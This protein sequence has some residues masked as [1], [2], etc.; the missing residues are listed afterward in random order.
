VLGHA[1]KRGIFL[2]L[3]FLIMIYLFTRSFYSPFFILLIVL[4]LLIAF[5]SEDYRLF[6]WITITFF[7]SHLL[8]GYLDNFIGSFQLPQFA[9]VLLSQLLIL[10]PIL[11]M[12]MV[13]NKFNKST[14]PYFRKP[15]M[16]KD[17]QLF[18]CISWKL[19][20]IIISI[21]FILFLIGTLIIKRDELT[22]LHLLFS[23][24]FSI[25]HTGLGEVLWRGILLPHFIA[26]TNKWLGI[27]VTSSAFGL[28]MTI[29]GFSSLTTFSYIIL[30]LLFGYLT[31]K[32]NS[33]LPSI[34]THTMIMLLLLIGG[35]VTLPI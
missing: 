6:A 17:I 27:L 8:L 16:T 29:F 22:Y 31:I 15:D 33:I 12:H 20:S 3:Q 21:L 19:F 10:V 11:M 18:N 4:F 23:L 32:T 1:T 9:L 34:V 30:G 24:S 5:L 7:L 26:I 28:N 25:I 14:Y 35:S 2:S 13:R